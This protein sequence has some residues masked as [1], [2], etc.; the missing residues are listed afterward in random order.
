MQTRQSKKLKTCKEAILVTLIVT[1]GVVIFA[2]IV[3]NYQVSRA[4][5][6]VLA[7]TGCQPPTWCVVSSPNPDLVYNELDGIAVIG[8]NDAWAVGVDGFPN[9]YNRRAITEHWDGGSWTVISPTQKGD[10][11]NNL[12][13]VTAVSSN[14]VWAVGSYYTAT[15][16]N[17]YFQYPLIQH[18]SNGS[19]QDISG[20]ISP[21]AMC[22]GSALAAVAAL[23]DNDVWAIGAY[24][25]GDTGMC[26]PPPNP[27]ATNVKVNHPYAQHCS[28]QP[29]VTCTL[30]L[31]P[32]AGVG[33]NAVNGIAAIST[34]NVWAVGS[35]SSDG[36][37]RSV[38]APRPLILHYTGVWT[39]TT[40]PSLTVDSVLNA[41][42]YYNAN[43]IWAVGTQLVSGSQ[44]TLVEHYDGSIWKVAN[45]IPNPGANNI[46]RSV[47][48]TNERDIWAVGQYDTNSSTNSLILHWHGFSNNDINGD[49]WDVITGTNPSTYNNQFMGVAAVPG[50]STPITHTWAVGSYNSGGNTLVENIAAPPAP[51]S[52]TSYY[53]TSVDPN[54]HYQ[55]GCAA[56]QRGENG[57][58][59][60][61]YG[62]PKDWG[63]SSSHSR[64][65]TLLVG[66][67]ATA[68]IT[69]SSFSGNEIQYSVERF[70]DGYAN[71]YGK[72][73]TSTITIAIG[74]NNH[75]EDG[76]ASLTSAHAAAWATMTNQIANHVV[77]YSMISGMAAAIDAE[78]DFADQSSTDYDFSKVLTWTNAFSGQSFESYYDFGSTDGYPCPRPEPPLPPRLGCSNWSASQFYTLTWGIPAA[79]PIPEIYKPLYASEWYQL[80]HW[81]L[82][83]HLDLPRFYGEMT[84]CQSSSC[85]PPNDYSAEQGWQTLWMKLNGDPNMVQSLIWSTDVVCSNGSPR[86]GCKP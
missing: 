56:A 42:D 83:N 27:P 26:F 30:T 60:L 46:L 15:Y 72:T 45:N 86:Q 84:E 85:T 65:G 77:S 2:L 75:N 8:Y 5:A 17:N 6:A 21:D 63:A 18:Y 3:S 66:T 49:K 70:A 11:S 44:Q 78:P 16:P 58:V 73:Q 20:T 79:R 67:G 38:G 13:A 28:L 71:C 48:M 54:A 76:L 31:P 55:Q 61:D 82:D 14:S 80:K 32:Y 37:P 25:V 43:D 50:N 1:A 64:Y 62:K 4:R 10:G 7:Q 57:V 52:T 39:T 53:E 81:A 59:V 24:N 36:I 19:W 74:I 40:S 51:I 9:R 29:V 41:V 69:S 47:F 23:S 68:Y 33:Y 34:T 35:Y 12:A 22:G